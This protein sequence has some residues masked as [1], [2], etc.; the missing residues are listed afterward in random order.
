[1]AKRSHR[2]RKFNRYTNASSK[3]KRGFSPYLI[4]LFSAIAAVLIDIVEQAG[5]EL[6][7]IGIAVEK[8]FQ[9]GGDQIRERGLCQTNFS[10]RAGP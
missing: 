4:I 3:R 2:H 8:G 1:M 7:G 5:A 9:H 6:V 10:F